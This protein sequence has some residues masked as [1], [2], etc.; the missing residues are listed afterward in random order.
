M[1]TFAVRHVDTANADIATKPQSLLH[2]LHQLCDPP[3]HFIDMGL[4]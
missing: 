4:L 1:S 2:R 3:D